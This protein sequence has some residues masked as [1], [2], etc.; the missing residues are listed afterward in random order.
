MI[1]KS[2]VYPIDKDVDS[3]SIIVSVVET[4]CKKVKTD[5]KDVIHLHLLTEE[6]LGLLNA[7]VYVEDGQF[8]IEKEEKEYRIHVSATANISTEEK[9]ELVKS[10]SDGKNQSY[11]GVSGKIFSVIDSLFTNEAYDAMAVTA[12]D[13]QMYGSVSA[14]TN[15]AAWSLANYYEATQK[16]TEEWYGYER[17]ILLKIA[18]DVLVSVRGDKVHITVV[19]ISGQ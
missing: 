14:S 4:F 19:K 11:K 17:S 7:I 3:S 10:S 13:R 12:L 8:Y 6:V 9:E 2:L 15:A 1:E 16:D 18:D 5:A